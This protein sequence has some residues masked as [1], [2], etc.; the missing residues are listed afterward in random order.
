MKNTPL[1]LRPLSRRSFVQAMLAAGVAPLVVPAR[2]LGAAAPS[3]KITVGVIGVG[4]QGHGDMRNFL[5]QDDVRVTAICDVNQRNL[6]RARKTIA[7]AYGGADVKVQED[8]RT[9]NE[10]PSIDAVLMALPVHWH[11]IPSIDAIL[12]GKHIFHEKPMALSFE[13]GR[14]VRAAVRKTGVVFQFGTQ[15]RS[16]LKFRWACELAL[17]GRIGRIREIEVCAPAGKAG[18]S[19]GAQP[20]P[21][22]VDWDRW[23]GPAPATGFHE[24]KLKRDNHENMAAFSLGMISCWGIHHLDVAQWGNGADATGPSLI[25]G[26]GT[27]APAGDHDAIQTWRVRYEFDGRPPIAFAS[28]GTPGF[29]HGIKFVGEAGW[30]HV[31]RGAITASDETLLRDPQCKVG[32]MALKLPVSTHHTRDFVDAIRRRGRAICDVEAALRG[33][34]LCQ[35]ALIAIRTG[36]ALRWDPA[37]ERI[38]GDDV[39]ATHLQP[40]PFRGEWRLPAV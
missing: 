23:V 40:R 7:E 34:T 5:S 24:E 25:R 18:P 28:E 33:D 6:D 20:L 14:R 1:R 10:D 11:S 32:A 4:A 26:Q 37:A 22:H 2:L 17:N 15:Q 3:N 38:L 19:Y 30:V 39:A 9:L 35:L 31:D 36:R 8:F 29:K 27:F 16:N 21:P 13:E 12:R